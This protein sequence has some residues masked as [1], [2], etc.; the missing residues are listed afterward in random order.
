M[1]LGILTATLFIVVVAS[2]KSSKHKDHGSHSKK[3][4]APV[5]FDLTQCVRDFATK[6]AEG[7]H[8]DLI[9]WNLSAAAA[10]FP[11]IVLEGKTPFRI[12]LK[13]I[14]YGNNVHS[15]MSKE[16]TNYTQSFMN[17]YKKPQPGIYRSDV[18]A[19]IAA[20]WNLHSAF[21][22][23]FSLVTSTH[24]PKVYKGSQERDY[25]FDLNDTLRVERKG[26]THLIRNKTFTVN[27]G[28][29]I[30]VTQTVRETT[31]VRSF[32][33]DVVLVGYF[34]IELRTRGDEPGSWI[35]CVTDLRCAHLKQTGKDEMTFRINGTFEEHYPVSA[36]TLTKHNLKKNEED[37]EVAP[38][39]NSNSI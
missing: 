19:P 1:R 18:L 6:F 3:Q 33:V 27:P 5:I 36:I 9:S 15:K 26:H 2:K 21:K 17:P 16:S 20:I 22:S 11:E 30:E 10:E 7:K 24:P 29:E 4:G 37:T 35:F 14:V 13:E 25:E 28:K 12:K 34:G 8:R 23:E 39:A 31:K 32:H 38:T